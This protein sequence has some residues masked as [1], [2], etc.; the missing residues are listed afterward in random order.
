MSPTP[1]QEEN[2]CSSIKINK[3]EACIYKS[4]DDQQQE[5]QEKQKQE[6]EK[7]QNI[8][9]TLGKVRKTCKKMWKVHSEKLMK[10]LNN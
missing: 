2:A 7:K 9:D 4:Q 8:K 6:E 5:K 1:E 10:K 3:K